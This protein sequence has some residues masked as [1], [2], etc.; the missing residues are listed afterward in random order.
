VVA[1][2]G[3]EYAPHHIVTYLIELAG[4]FNR[5]YASHRI[6]DAA[7]PTSPYRLALTQAFACVMH[8]GLGLLGIK[9]P[10]SM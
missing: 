2:A 6:I 4:E 10:D 9:V 3:K 8:S 5:F 1:R 7:D